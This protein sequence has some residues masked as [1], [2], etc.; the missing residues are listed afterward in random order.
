[1]PANAAFAAL[2]DQLAQEVPQ[3]ASSGELMSVTENQFKLLDRGGVPY[4]DYEPHAR[5]YSR[6]N[7]D[8]MCARAKLN[9]QENQE[10]TRDPNA[11]LMS[12]STHYILKK[13]AALKGVGLT[14]DLNIGETQHQAALDVWISFVGKHGPKLW[15]ASLLLCW[16]GMP[17]ED[18]LRL[19]GNNSNKA[20]QM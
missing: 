4:E 1:M 18:I 2:V 5:Q 3:H 11:R 8:A 19:N 9:I 13:M 12:G 15:D 16:H 7:I 6:Q 10:R 20:L 14:M 17:L